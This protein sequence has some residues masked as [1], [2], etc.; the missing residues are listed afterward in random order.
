ME[1]LNKKKYLSTKEAA[2]R[3]RSYKR[4]MEGW[5]RRNEGPPF[6]RLGDAQNSTVVYPV[7]GL[8]LWLSA[9]TSTMVK[10]RQTQPDGTRGGDPLQRQQSGLIGRWRRA[11]RLAKRGVLFPWARGNRARQ[12]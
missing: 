3:I 4:T 5:R 10:D 1:C 9:H 8:E 7:E 12:R 6:I 11:K 2:E